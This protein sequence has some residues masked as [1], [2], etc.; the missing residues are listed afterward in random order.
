MNISLD[1]DDT[2]S[3]DPAMWDKAIDLFQKSGH[4]VFCVTKRFEENAE[5][6][7]K[8]LRI[9]IIFALKSKSEAVKKQG[10]RIDVWIDDRPKSIVWTRPFRKK[11]R[12]FS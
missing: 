5:D 12:V 8:A 1:F 9:P 4:Q 2:Y 6:I 3:L 10:I 11:P 7:R